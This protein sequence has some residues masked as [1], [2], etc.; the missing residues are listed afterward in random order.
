MKGYFIMK[1]SS[2]CKEAIDSCLATRSFAVAHLYNDEKPMKIHIHDCYEI[3]FSISG[4][5]QFLID[6]RC[7]D[8]KPGDIFFINQYESHYLSQIDNVTHERIIL[9]IHP[10]YLKQ[11]STVF[12]DLDYCFSCRSTGFGHQLS[13]SS[14]EQKRFL[15]Y[16]HRFSESAPFG[17][18]LLDQAYFTE[19]MVYLN[20]LFLLR[21]SR[22]FR[23]QSDQAVLSVTAEAPAFRHGQIDEILSYINQHL[24]EELTI[25]ALAENFFIS[26][27]Y[28]C[29]IFKESTGTT[30]N[31]Y[32]TAR[33]ITLAKSLLSEGYS[34]SDTCQRCGFQDYSNFLKAFT[35]AVGISPKKYSQFSLQG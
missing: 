12:T 10:D 5:K 21:C 31:K 13:L 9:S 33:R 24:T 18:D 32:I 25:A 4:G 20:H 8:F 15:Y 7:Y 28:L 30:I 23:F 19:L 11:L 27:S 22:D 35:K 26:V 3:Y 2:S 6:N 34:V 14:E 17:Q 1:L 16:I 29:R